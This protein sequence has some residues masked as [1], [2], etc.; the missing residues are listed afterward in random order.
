MRI[1]HKFKGDEKKIYCLYCFND[2]VFIN[3][4]LKIRVPVKNR[5]DI[6]EMH[7]VTLISFFISLKLIKIELAGFRFKLLMYLFETI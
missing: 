5:I 3:L 4:D 1:F 7:S 2:N 6:R